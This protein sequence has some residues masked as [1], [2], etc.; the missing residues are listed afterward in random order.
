MELLL[1]N[2]VLVYLFPEVLLKSFARSLLPLVLGASSVT[3]SKTLMKPPFGMY[4]FV[5]EAACLLV[6]PLFF[7]RKLLSIFFDR[8]FSAVS[9]ESCK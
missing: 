2:C 5:E 6:V 1:N 7:R 9:N 8:L 3:S 4:R